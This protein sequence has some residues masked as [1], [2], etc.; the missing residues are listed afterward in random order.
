M[1]CSYCILRSNEIVDF[2]GTRLEIKPQMAGN[3]DA[4]DLGRAGLS[5]E[6]QLV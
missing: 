1:K 4:G 6:M 2:A 3:D 5:A